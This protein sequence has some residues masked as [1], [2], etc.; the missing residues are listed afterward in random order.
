VIE[1]DKSDDSNLHR[2]YP[3]LKAYSAGSK[4]CK[5]LSRKCLLGTKGIILLLLSIISLYSSYLCIEVNRKRNMEIER[6]CYESLENYMIRHSYFTIIGN[7]PIIIILLSTIFIKLTAILMN[8]TCPSF[9]I[10]LVKNDEIIS[11]KIIKIN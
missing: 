3:A 5:Y 4:I 7:S 6:N 9:R 10:K 8:L 11:K 1:E 2:I